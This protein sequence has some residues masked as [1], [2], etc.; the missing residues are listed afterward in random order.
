V[1][2]GI[3]HIKG[4]RKIIVHQTN[5]PQIAR[6]A[7]LYSYKVDKK[8]LDDNDNPVILPIPIDAN[9]HGW[10]AVRYGLDGY[11]QNRGGLGVWAKLAE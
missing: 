8:Q 3:T 9:N 4:F 6:E 11:I 10:D 5:C 2:D 7:R 1:E